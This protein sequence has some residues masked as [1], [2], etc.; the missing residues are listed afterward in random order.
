MLQDIDVA[1]DH[2]PPS[3]M[4]RVAEWEGGINLDFR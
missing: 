2:A 1:V 3:L 4:H